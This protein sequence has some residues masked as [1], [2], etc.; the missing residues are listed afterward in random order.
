MLRSEMDIKEVEKLRNTAQD[1][2]NK[3]PNEWFSLLENKDCLL[4]SDE[5]GYKLYF[6]K[7]LLK[8]LGF[9]NN[10]TK[11]KELQKKNRELPIKVLYCG[12]KIIIK[13]GCKNE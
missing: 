1:E 6:K 4:K 7:E 2:A 5:N 11:V 12:D 3:K 8:I 13:R 10:D 9:M